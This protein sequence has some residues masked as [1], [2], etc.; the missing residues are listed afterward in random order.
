MACNKHRLFVES[1]VIARH[2]ARVASRRWVRSCDYATKFRVVPLCVYIAFR[3]R[4]ID[5]LSPVT[6]EPQA[7]P[8][9]R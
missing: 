6:F 3:A 7:A 2:N 4:G 1:V 9:T 8:L 5:G